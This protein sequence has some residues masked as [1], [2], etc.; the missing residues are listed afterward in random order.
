MLHIFIYLSLFIERERERER[1]HEHE[2]YRG[3]ER[4]KERIRSRLCTVSTK[5][6]IITWAQIKSQMLNWLSHPDAPCFT[7]SKAWFKRLVLGAHQDLEKSADVSYI[8]LGSVSTHAQ[9]PPLP[10]SS[11]RVRDLLQSRNLHWCIVTTQSS[12]FTLGFTLGVLRSMDV[13]KCI[14][15]SIHHDSIIQSFFTDLKLL[16]APPS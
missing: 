13:D 7:F 4:G 3:K 6:E 10:M 1:E 16:R 12:Q 9:C 2:W 14:M 8:L 15:A 5:H 11:T